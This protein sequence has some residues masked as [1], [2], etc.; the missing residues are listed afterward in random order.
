M[1]EKRTV[2]IQDKNAKNMEE[3]KVFSTEIR[4]ISV[5]FFRL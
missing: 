3:M 4:I 5:E 2:N 1:S